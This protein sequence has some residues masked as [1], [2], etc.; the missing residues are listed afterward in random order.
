MLGQ[1]YSSSMRPQSS[2]THPA[3]ERVQLELLR[4]A[5]VQVRAARMRSLTKDTFRLALRALQR[6]HPDWSRDELFVEFIALNH[7]RELA[8]RLRADLRRRGRLA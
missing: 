3:A 2:D 8:A 5:P 1:R 7:G 4:A 6:A